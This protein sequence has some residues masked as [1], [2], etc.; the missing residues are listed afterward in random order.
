M[1]KN[2]AIITRQKDDATVKYPGITPITG[3]KD[4]QSDA[5]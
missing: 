5:N 4:Y 2:D 1:P 3:Y